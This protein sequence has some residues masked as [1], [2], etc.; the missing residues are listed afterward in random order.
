V[1]VVGFDDIEL[2]SFTALT[3]V[4]QPMEE[5]SIESDKPVK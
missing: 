2:A 5:M 1:A 3:T 4:R